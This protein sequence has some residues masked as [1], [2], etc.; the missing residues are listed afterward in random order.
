M[1]KAQL[2][3]FSAHLNCHHKNWVLINSIHFLLWFSRHL[4]AIFMMSAMSH[5]SNE[6]FCSWLMYIYSSFINDKNFFFLIKQKIFFEALS[7]DIE[8]KLIFF[9]VSFFI[10][11]CFC[12]DFP[13]WEITLLSTFYLSVVLKN[14]FKR[15]KPD[16]TEL[17]RFKFE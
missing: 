15:S 10:A 17:N 11:N 13:K 12:M 5:M 7:H 6:V 16:A 4:C 9:F 3:N 1:R 14:Q 8:N 2:R